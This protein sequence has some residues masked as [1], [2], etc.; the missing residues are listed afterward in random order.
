MFDGKEVAETFLDFS[1]RPAPPTNLSCS[2][3]FDIGDSKMSYAATLKWTGTGTGAEAERY[4]VRW[5][6]EREEEQQQRDVSVPETTLVVPEGDKKAVRVQIWTLTKDGLRSDES[7]ETTLPV[8][9]KL[10]SGYVDDLER[11]MPETN[12]GSKY[13]Y[14]V[15]NPCSVG[16]RFKSTYYLAKIASPLSPFPPAIITYSGT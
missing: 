14:Q 2:W 10:L 11:K 12:T 4:E 6:T 7:L 5:T 8:V 3:G 1:T 13:I 16:N 15:Q 9:P